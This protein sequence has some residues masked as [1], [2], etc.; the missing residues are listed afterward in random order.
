MTTRTSFDRALDGYGKLV[1]HLVL[2]TG[3]PRPEVLAALKRAATGEP[4]QPL[5]VNG[6]Y[7]TAEQREV[8]RRAI[9]KV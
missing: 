2:G 1:D 6:R 5:K 3:R 7:L 8:R 9:A 4:V